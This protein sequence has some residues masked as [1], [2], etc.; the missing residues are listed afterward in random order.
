[1]ILNILVIFVKNSA[2]GSM[3]TSPDDSSPRS[4]IKICRYDEK[5]FRA[6]EAS[7]VKIILIQQAKTNASGKFQH[8]RRPIEPF[9]P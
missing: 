9:I 2:R 7:F 8:Q 1:M 5:S 6:S 3:S 4:K